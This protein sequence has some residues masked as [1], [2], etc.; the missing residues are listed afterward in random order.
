MCE[1]ALEHVR[2]VRAGGCDGAPLGSLRSDVECERP[3]VD[4]RDS[5]HATLEEIILQG[6]CSPPRRVTWRG[7]THDKARDRRTLRLTILVVDAVVADQGIRHHNVL[8]RVRRIG[9]DLL[10]PSHGRIE[11]DLSQR[12]PGRSEAVAVEAAAV[13]QQEIRRV[14]LVNTSQRSGAS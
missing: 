3:R 5:D 2:F 10:V 1:H 7:L 14:A 13:L 4:T 6:P 12:R 11:D 8:P 9:E